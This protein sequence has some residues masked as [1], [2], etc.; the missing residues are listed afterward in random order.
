MDPATSDRSRNRMRFDRFECVPWTG[1]DEMY[2][3]AESCGAGKWFSQDGSATSGVKCCSQDDFTCF[4]CPE[5]VFGGERCD[6]DETPLEDQ[7]CFPANAT[8][9]EAM[10]ICEKAGL[11]LCTEEEVSHR[12]CCNT[13]CADFPIWT[14]TNGLPKLRE[15]VQLKRARRLHTLGSYEEFVLSFDLLPRGTRTENASVIHFSQGGDHRAE[16]DSIPAVWFAAKTTKLVVRMDM[17]GMQD[18]I[19]TANAELPLGK[20][21]KITVKLHGLSFTVKARAHW[22]D[23]AQEE[24]RL[25]C[26]RASLKHSTDLPNIR[27]FVSDPWSPA[28]DAWIS[29]LQYKPIE[30]AAAALRERQPDETFGEYGLVLVVGFGLVS[31]VL[32]GTVCKCRND[33]Y[34]YSEVP[35]PTGKRPPTTNAL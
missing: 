6:A 10:R 2:V 12:L 7:N 32:T 1:D 18:T 31:A 20:T 11:R 24:E 17:P 8:H 15:P 29:N 14:A 22:P 19:C 26:A 25:L 23:C 9:S 5:S 30:S 16:G 21:S 3:S 27:V 34:K 35:A 4:S 33:A 28:A 13:G